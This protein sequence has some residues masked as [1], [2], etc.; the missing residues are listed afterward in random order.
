M[1]LEEGVWDLPP[2]SSP[3]SCSQQSQYELMRPRVLRRNGRGGRMTSLKGSMIVSVN[4]PYFAPFPGFFYKAGLSDLLVILDEV[5]FPR[6]TTWI[7][8]NRFKNDQGTL[9]LTIPVWKKGLGLQKISEV[10]IC[11]E[12]RW[13]RKHLESLKSAYGRSPFFEEHV[14]FL[15]ELFTSPPALL[16]EMNLRIISSLLSRLGVEAGFVLLSSLGVKGAG[17]NLLVE[18]CR[19]VGASTFLAPNQARKYLTPEVFQERG[20]SLRFFRYVAPVYPQLWGEFVANLS[21]FDLLFNCGPKAWEVLSRQQPQGARSPKA[22]KSPAGL[23]P[24]NT[25]SPDGC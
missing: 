15:Q 20:V 1:G 12:G 3:K 23:G 2:A 5:Q 19:A 9:W 24:A 7:S 8:R 22:T 11:H 6:G 13:P 17:E 21:A 4:Q 18:I 16:L 14:D 25:S 10:R